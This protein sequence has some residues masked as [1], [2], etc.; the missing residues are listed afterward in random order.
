MRLTLAAIG[1]LRPGAERTLYERYIERALPLGRQIGLS[2]IISW[3]VS[4]SHARASEERKSQEASTL[5]QSPN[6]PL[7][8]SST[9]LLI[10]DPQGDC[11]ST[12]DF[13]ELLTHLRN[14]NHGTTCILI[15]GPDGLHHSLVHRAYKSIAFGAMTMPHQLVRI[16]LAEQIY[17]ICTRLCGHPYHR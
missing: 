9:P 16:L 12:E 6:S 11:L 15:G 17:R 7:K 14:Q 2:P 3:E 10:C 13:T 5:I 1:K 4:E 8:E